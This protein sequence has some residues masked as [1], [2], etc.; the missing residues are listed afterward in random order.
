[1]NSLGERIAFYRKK[2]GL[3][4]EQLAEKCS[5]SAQAV[6]KWENDLTSPDIMLIA[7]L[8]ELFGISC[9][10]LLGARRFE[11]G[12]IDPELVDIGKTLLKIKV[13]SV[14]GDDVNVNLP[15]SLADVILKSGSAC[16]G[17]KGSLLAEIDFEQIIT[18]IKAGAVGKLVDVKSAAGD[19]V[20]VWVE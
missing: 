4:Q 5:V 11:T 19:L 6:S 10:E 20:E 7:P 13:K 16:M 1:M 12:A 3:T 9:D 14:K 2:K 8:A 15:V 17:D 18:L